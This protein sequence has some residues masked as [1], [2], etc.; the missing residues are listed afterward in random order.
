MPECSVT[1]RM[2]M[3][4]DPVNHPVHYTHS[5]LMPHECIDVAR[6]LDF[7]SGNAFKYVFRAGSK[8]SAVQDLEKAKWYLSVEPGR[9]HDSLPEAVIATWRL[10][11]NAPEIDMLRL[12]ALRRIVAGDTLPAKEII[13]RMIRI[14]K[15]NENGQG[16][17][18]A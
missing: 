7:C 3:Q 9:Q 8:D 1:R 17:G 10:P 6:F 15:E 14:Y 2:A 5:W 11:E 13:D 16:K 12:K 18:K 4:N